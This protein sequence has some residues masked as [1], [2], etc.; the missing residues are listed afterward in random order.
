MTVSTGVGG[1]ASF[2]GSDAVVLLKPDQGYRLKTTEIVRSYTDIGG[3]ETMEKV[4]ATQ[5]A[6]SCR[7]NITDGL[8]LSKL[9]EEQLKMVHIS[10]MAELEEDRRN[11]PTVTFA[12]G[13]AMDEYIK[14]FNA[15]GKKVTL[16][17]HLTT[18]SRPGS[19]FRLPLFPGFLIFC[20]RENLRPLP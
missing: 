3:K 15:A 18:L 19:I 16:L 11:V 1:N 5:T 9:T 13:S 20:L 14:R 2:D 7:V 12:T 10:I 17:N 6:D 4:A 8:D